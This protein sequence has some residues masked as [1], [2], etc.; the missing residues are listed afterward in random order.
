MS[1]SFVAKDG[2]DL[3]RLGHGFLQLFVDRFDVWF[4]FSTVGINCLVPRRQIK[5]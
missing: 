5:L 4:D 3:K 2:L 1:L